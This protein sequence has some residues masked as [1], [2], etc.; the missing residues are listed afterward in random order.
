LG[1]S[2]RTRLAEHLILRAS[3]T[4]L[5]S[6]YRFATVNR[7]ALDHSLSTSVSSQ[8]DG[9]PHCHLAAR[10]ICL[11]DH[12]LCGGVVYNASAV[13]SDP[14]MSRN[15]KPVGVAIGHTTLAKTTI[16][17]AIAVSAFPDTTVRRHDGVLAQRVPGTKVCTSHAQHREVESSPL[18]PERRVG[19]SLLS[20]CDGLITYPE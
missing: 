8:K 17:N 19:W 13:T 15:A 10:A 4:E 3:C 14:C 20:T 5:Y 6:L 9:K 7:S 16:R 18:S 11:R 12:L 2:G 1:G